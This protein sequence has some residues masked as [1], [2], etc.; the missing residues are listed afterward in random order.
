ML[1]VKR[2][3]HTGVVNFF[4]EDEPFLAVASIARSTGDADTE[5]FTWRCHAPDDSR[6][7][8]ALDESAAE[9]QVLYSYATLLAQ[10]P[11]VEDHRFAAG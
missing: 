11:V 8:F 7:G 10:R 2:C 9:R 1:L 5:G 3:P 6:S 4:S